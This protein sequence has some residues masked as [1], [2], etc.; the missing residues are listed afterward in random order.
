MKTLIRFFFLS[1]FIFACTLIILY[2]RRE[3]LIF[4]NLQNHDEE[5]R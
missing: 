2:F 3:N 1:S 4:P 5:K